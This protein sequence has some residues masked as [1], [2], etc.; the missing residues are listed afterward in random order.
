MRNVKATTID[1]MKKS[2]LKFNELMTTDDK[3]EYKEL[4]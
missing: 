3:R 2:Q 1:S 4:F